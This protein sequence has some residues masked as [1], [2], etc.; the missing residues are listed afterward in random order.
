LQKTSFLGANGI[1]VHHGS[2]WVGNT[3][4][5][6]ILRIPIQADGSAGPISTAV[7]G[8]SGG[9]DNFTVVGCDDTI[10][11]T[12]IQ[13]DQIEIIKP[14][15][16]PLVVLTAADGLSNPTDVK[17]HGNTLYVTSGAYFHLAGANLLVAHISLN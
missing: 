17:V 5:A 2:V 6:T 14:G 10:I 12:E 16:A 4:Q 9:I 1:V 15:Q 7:T 3:D 13:T 8:L 11:A